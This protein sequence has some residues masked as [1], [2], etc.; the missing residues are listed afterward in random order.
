MK[1]ILRY[2]G[3][4]GKSDKD[5]C[6]L[7][8]HPMLY[9]SLDC[10]A[11]AKAWIDS[12][13]GIKRALLLKN[14][15]SWAL[16]FVYM[17]DYG[18]LSTTFQTLN[19]PLW[20][21]LFSGFETDIQQKL[22]NPYQHGT[23]GSN[24]FHHDIGADPDNFDRCVWMAEAGDHHHRYKTGSPKIQVFSKK[25]TPLWGHEI[26][27]RNEFI[28]IGINLFFEGRSVDFLD[29]PPVPN[30][31]K[32]FC[33]ICDWIA[34]NPD[35]FPFSTQEN[36]P[37]DYFESRIPFAQR[38]LKLCGLIN[39]IPKNF[40]MSGLFPEYKPRGIQGIN[41]PIEEGGLYIIEAPTG[42]GKT[43]F[44]LSIASSLIKKGHADSILFAL[45]T[46]ATANSM[47]ER[48]EKV[49]SRMY[50]EGSN[51]VLA[52]GKSR[53]NEGFLALCRNGAKRESDV[54]LQQCSEWL[55]T[56]KKRAFLGQI[57]VCTI[58]QVL[59]GALPVRHNFIRTFAT[60]RG[61]L[62][63]DEVHAYDS[64]MN[65][66]LD[67]ILK[68]QRQCNGNAILLSATLPS[69]RKKDLIGK[70]SGNL[71]EKL[72]P[73]YPLITT[74]LSN[75]S[76]KEFT[77]DE[78]TEDKHVNIE[79]RVTDNVLPDEELLK[80]IIKYAEMGFVVAVICNLVSD[81]QYT[82]LKLLQLS[83][84]VKVDL[85]HGRYAFTDRNRIE[86]DIIVRYEKERKEASGSILVATQ[87]IEQSLDLDFDFMVT[88]LCPVELLFQRLGR[89][90]RHERAHRPSD[91]P[92]CIVLSPKDNDFGLHG[93]IY[94]N[95]A[96]LWRT[97]FLVQKEPSVL[98]PEAY[99]RWIELA[100]SKLEN[101]PELITKA[102][103]Q[104]AIEELGKEY[105]ARN[106]SAMDVSD[107]SDSRAELLTRDGEMGINLLP[108]DRNGFLLDE[109]K[110]PL[111][112]LYSD[113]KNLGANEVVQL[114]TI[115]CPPGWQ[116]KITP[117]QKIDDYIVITVTQDGDSWSYVSENKEFKLTY[118]RQEG[119]RKE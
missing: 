38:S 80:E 52:H 73:E 112:S 3:K 28:N 111:S 89:L 109:N 25:G 77:P 95:A 9:H 51:I 74:V 6:E 117:H 34:S 85:F 99:R 110:T 11:V 108:V 81:A 113:K 8:W 61:V 118:S 30:T 40:G 55:A 36:S 7:L 67:Q 56:S 10:A 53:F 75:H 94:K 82:W 59:I 13:L 64:Y 100:H 62:I 71:S 66:L 92:R 17:H 86:N 46:Q 21:K 93:Y 14:N 47:F 88:Q 35:F 76:F 57:G 69:E 43:E 97:R 19:I 15:M 105:L 5:E 72:S 20:K 37:I 91:V 39:T 50:P 29:A 48:L 79:L 65:G 22:A 101:E 2:W 96:Y 87:V 23:E 26:K 68:K 106:I 60:G 33:T 31:F 90:Y 54:G 107:I 70:W 119:L 115:P 102:D 114:Q 78:K 58:D 103:E 45:P 84:T 104:F 49:A 32:G 98:F 1:D 27:A 12:S 42:S 16:F 44:A 4:S 18:K 116:G 83:N 24:K 41:V 63:V